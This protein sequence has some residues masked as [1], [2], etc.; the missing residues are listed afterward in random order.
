[1]FRYQHFYGSYDYT[2]A[3]R[4]WYRREVRILRNNKKIYSY[5]DA[6][7]FRIRDTPLSAGRKLRVRLIPATIYHYGWVKHPEAQL[8]KQQNFNRLWHS[9]EKVKSLLG[10]NNTYNYDGAEPLSKYTGSHPAVMQ[11][12]IKAI[13]WQFANDPTRIRNSW[14]NYLSNCI[15]KLTGYRPFEYRN[16]R[17]LRF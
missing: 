10:E 13:N 7:G 11:P 2:G 16:Y 17:L 4:R 1:L 3:S 6:Q 12:R 15:E 5:R 8:R 9:D 14:K